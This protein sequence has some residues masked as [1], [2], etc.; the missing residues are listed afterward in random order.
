LVIKD[1]EIVSKPA[2]MKRV[3]YSPITVLTPILSSSNEKEHKENDQ[4]D[5]PENF[6]VIFTNNIQLHS[7]MKRDSSDKIKSKKVVTIVEPR[8]EQIPKLKLTFS[9]KI[10]RQETPRNLKNKSPQFTFKSQNAFSLPT[11]IEDA[12]FIDDILEV[13]DTMEDDKD[14]VAASHKEP[15]EAKVANPS[16]IQM[17]W[18]PNVTLTTEI[19]HVAAVE[20][21]DKGR[22]SSNA[23]SPKVP[24]VET[25][26][27]LVKPEKSQNST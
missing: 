16:T 26:S 18:N 14:I 8:K 19:V 13:L 15:I 17:F 11:Q 6:N 10:I 1:V 2:Y 22:D 27:T 4:Q 9:P 24:P 21:K 7:I 5:P 20:L 3:N 12:N 23:V 25:P